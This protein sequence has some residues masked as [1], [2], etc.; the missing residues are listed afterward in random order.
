MLIVNDVMKKMFRTKYK[1]NDK[2]S[3]QEAIS[4]LKKS[5]YSQMQCLRILMEELNLNI[6]DADKIILSSDAWAKEKISNA[7]FREDFEKDLENS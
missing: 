4:L 7:K 1:S 6:A 2:N 5:G 3:I